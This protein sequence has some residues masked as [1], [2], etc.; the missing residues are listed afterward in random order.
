M[1]AHHT[2]MK[3]PE[4]VDRTDPLSQKTAKKQPP[5]TK[6]IHPKDP[7]I[8]QMDITGNMDMLMATK[9]T[10]LT[11]VITHHMQ[12]HMAT[13][14]HKPTCRIQ[15]PHSIQ[16]R[17]KCLQ[18]AVKVLVVKVLDLPIQNLPLPPEIPCWIK[19]YGQIL[20]SDPIRFRIL[21]GAALNSGAIRS[22]F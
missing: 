16:L 18:R 5:I 17:K 22:I 15:T 20:S 14:A 4:V 1:A 2:S 6:A 13:S 8:M 7:S 21:V 9:V 12:I 10:H 11:P 3:V 19:Q